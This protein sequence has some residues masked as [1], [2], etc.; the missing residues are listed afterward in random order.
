MGI[1]PKTVHVRAYERLRHGKWEHVVS[2]FR[3]A[4]HR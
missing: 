3:S 2:H 4:P 1:Y